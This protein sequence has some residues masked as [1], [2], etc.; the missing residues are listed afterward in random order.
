MNK[1]DTVLDM[2]DSRFARLLEG[3]NSE[4]LHA[5]TSMAIE[6]AHASGAIDNDERRH[7]LA[8]HLRILVRQHRDLMLL[9]EQR[10]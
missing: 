1:H 7:Y 2:I 10:Q 4:Q 8:R 3:D 6:M 9:L 5:E